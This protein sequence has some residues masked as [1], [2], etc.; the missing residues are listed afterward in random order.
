MA[1]EGIT[2]LKKDVI[3]AL[4]SDQIKIKHCTI[5]LILIIDNAM[6]FIKILFPGEMIIMVDLF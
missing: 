3:N 2:Y 1:Y 6:T 5:Q 4:D